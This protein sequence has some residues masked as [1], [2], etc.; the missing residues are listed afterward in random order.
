MIS[1]LKRLLRHVREEKDLRDYVTIF[2]IGVY[3]LLLTFSLVP[4]GI[5]SQ[6]LNQD[7]AC[8]VDLSFDR[9]FCDNINSPA[10]FDDARK[11]MVLQRTASFTNINLIIMTVFGIISSLIYGYLLDRHRKHFKLIMSLPLIGS[12]ISYLVWIMFCIFFDTSKFQR[13]STFDEI[14]RAVF[15]LFTHFLNF[16]IELDAALLC[17]DNIDRRPVSNRNQQ[18]CLHRE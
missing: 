10:Y 4:I 16:R 12:L 5:A 6:Q 8:L 9:E 15:N 11:T 7:K 18:F 13:V 17:S 14:V 3:M 1:R 2:K